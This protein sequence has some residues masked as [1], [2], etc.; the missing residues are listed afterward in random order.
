MQKRKEINKII[1]TNKIW[2]NCTTIYK[3]RHLNIHSSIENII[4]SGKRLTGPLAEGGRN[5]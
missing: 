4:K 3:I 1:K 2:I 5:N